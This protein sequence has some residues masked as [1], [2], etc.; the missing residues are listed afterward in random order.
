MNTDV[1]LAWA[2]PQPVE[3]RVESRLRPQFK[4]M[5]RIR[6]WVYLCVLA[7]AITPSLAAFGQ[8][9]SSQDMASVSAPPKLDT[10]TPTRLSA[11]ADR[12]VGLPLPGTLFT[13]REQRDKM[14]R[15]RRRGGIVED[16]TTAPAESRVSVINGFVKR[17][18]GRDTVWVDDVMRRDPRAEMVQQLEP[19]MVGGN[20]AIKRFTP[21][22]EPK[23]PSAIIRRSIPRITNQLRKPTRKIAKPSF[24]K[25]AI[26]K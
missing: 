14:D 8:A 26:V 25:M 7:C 17:S 13:T 20:F 2:L 11:E 19:N 9:P 12:Q 24:R 23:P 21:A 16:E 10:S 15:T 22:V 3:I 18:D 4:S 6:T 1:I 5:P